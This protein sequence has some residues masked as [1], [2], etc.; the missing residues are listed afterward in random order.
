M[1]RT[2]KETA[3]TSCAPKSG[4][5]VIFRC[6][7]RAKFVPICA[8]HPQICVQKEKITLKKDRFARYALNCYEENDIILLK[9]QQVSNCNMHGTVH[10]GGYRL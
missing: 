10:T 3:Q 5:K 1:K 7:V 2:V 4:M 9:M 8:K 6:T